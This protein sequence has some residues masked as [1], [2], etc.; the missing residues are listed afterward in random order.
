MP[1][2]MMEHEQD[3]RSTLQE[4]I[5]DISGVELAPT[6]LLV[7]IYTPPEKTKSGIF[8]ADKTKDEYKYQGK[9]G[10]VMK[11]GANVFVDDRT[12][13]FHDFSADIGDWIVFRPA[14]GWPISVNKTPCRIISDYL[15][16]VKVS[17]P[18]VAY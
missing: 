5:G 18:D 11:T 17:H 15:V 16:K 1:H 6:E 10:L 14:D 2:I 12:V 7:A 8:L 3:P 4:S 13:Q 9:V